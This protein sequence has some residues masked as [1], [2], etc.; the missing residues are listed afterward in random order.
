MNKRL[1]KEVRL[2]GSGFLISAALACLPVL[3][4]PD[5]SGAWVSA[6]WLVLASA[7]AGSAGFGVELAE[8]TLFP[9]LSQPISRQE[10]W[11]EKMRT[12]AFALAPLSGALLL[13]D[14]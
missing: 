14:F 1:I 4:F 9:L 12:L 10:I 5:E 8:R 11:F 13:L 6:S 7:L 2:L 3:L